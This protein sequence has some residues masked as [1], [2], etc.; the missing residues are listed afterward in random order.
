MAWE[1]SAWNLESVKGDG[2]LPR[3]GKR[4]D[5]VLT[6]GGSE[7]GRQGGG[8]QGTSP[9]RQ[10]YRGKAY[11]AQQDVGTQ[12][13]LF[14]PWALPV[15]LGESP[16]SGR[17]GCALW[18]LR[19]QWTSSL[20]LKDPA[21]QRRR[22]GNQRALQSQSSLSLKK[23]FLTDPKGSVEE[24]AYSGHQTLRTSIQCGDICDVW[25]GRI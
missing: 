13:H 5:P 2:S 9:L 11:P 6:Q 16:V 10:K 14:K 3:N 22:G 1:S 21:G 7:K 25:G 19:G 23:K 17:A 24:P 12:K 15:S 18:L 8:E 4:T 20:F